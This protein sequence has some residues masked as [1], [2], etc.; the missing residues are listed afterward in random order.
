MGDIAT[1][2]IFRKELKN[3][4]VY[5]PGK[6]MEEVKKEYGLVEVI[7]LAS[8]E[9]PLGPSPK[10]IEKIMEKVSQINIYPDGASMEL[11]AV[12]AEKHGLEIENV[13]CGNGGEQLL[14]Y[15]TQALVNEGDNVIMADTTFVVTALGTDQ[16]GGIV[17]KIPLKN[18]KHDFK[19]MIEA[20]D[21]N[22]KLIYVCNPN[23]PVGNIMTDDEMDYLVKNISE[24]I[25]LVIDEAYYDYGIR[26]PEYSGGLNI[27]KNK[28]N[29]IVLRTLS[30]V[31]GIAGTRVGYVFSS[32]EIIDNITK[33]KNV[34]NV[35][36]LA[37]A[38]AMGALE[39]DE[40]I[41]NTVDLN[42]E[43][44]KLMEE[45]FDKKGLEYVKS[46][47]NFIFVDTGM[48]SKIVFEELMKLG[49]IIRGGFLWNWNTW[50]RVSTGTIE[51]TE[52]FTEVLDKVLLM[53]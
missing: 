30:K 27:L 46:N 4:G 51:Q 8:N 17:K 10:A 14:S 13:I 50:I 1:K 11:R 2:D 45:Y 23:N 28:K 15:I 7:K 41:E 6:P 34:F 19:K 47:A 36:L 9:N 49:V 52:I 22:T 26:N 48:D 42:Y 33:V 37:Q 5:I 38:A 21:E 44:L 43:S 20:A 16:M 12:L 31:A 35:N 32:K 53:K 3:M 25:V 29:T 24:D 39:D 40:H 18:Y